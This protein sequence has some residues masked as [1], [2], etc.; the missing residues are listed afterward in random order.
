MRGDSQT[1]VHTHTRTH[2]HTYTLHYIV[3]SHHI[4]SPYI[5]YH[6]SHTIHIHVHIHIHIYIYIYVY[7]YIYTYICTHTHIYIYIY[8]YIYTYSHI[9]THFHNN[10]QDMY[11][12]IHADLWWFMAI[13]CEPGFIQALF[14]LGLRRC[15]QLRKLCLRWSCDCREWIF[16]CQSQLD[17]A[18]LASLHFPTYPRWKSHEKPPG[19]ILLPGSVLFSDNGWHSAKTKLEL[20]QVPGIH[21]VSHSCRSCCGW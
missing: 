18:R 14:V 6:T 11:I 7:T 4:T 12:H 15:L 2:V 3:T 21:S 16:S 20:H 19:K 10:L 5:T 8:I 1:P 9:H 13:K 17:T